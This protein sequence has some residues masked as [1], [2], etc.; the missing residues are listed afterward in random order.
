MAEKHYKYRGPVSTIT[1]AAS[2]GGVR[3]VPLRPG[4]PVDLPPEDP[5]VLYLVGLELL[6]ELAA[7]TEEEEA[8]PRARRA[9]R[10]AP[11]EAGA[12]PD[13]DDTTREGGQ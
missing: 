4:C 2:G 5:A 12:T 9:P 1:V 7:D 3:E 8:T 11:V 10:R 13:G 6:E